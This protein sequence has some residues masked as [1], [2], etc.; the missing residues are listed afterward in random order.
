LM[1]YH[2]RSYSVLN[3]LIIGGRFFKRILWPQ[4]IHLMP[5]K[6][7][8]SAGSISWWHFWHK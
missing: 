7:S 8:S 2:K 1:K 3:R 6:V 4:I 5:G